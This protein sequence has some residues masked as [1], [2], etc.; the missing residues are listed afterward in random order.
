MLFFMATDAKAAI[1]DLLIT[2]LKATA[3]DAAGATITLERP[4]Q[5]QHGDFSCNVAMQLAKALR[6]K[7]RDIAQ[8]LL[9]NLPASPLVDKAE[10]AGA[11]FINLFLNRGHKQSVVNQILTSGARYGTSAAAERKKIQVEFV[12]ANPTGPLHVG[13][14]RGAAYGACVANVLAAAGHEVS[15]EFYI[16]D[17][18][19]QMDILAVSVWLRYLEARGVAVAFPADGYRGDYVRD[20]ARALDTQH[21]A[22]LQRDF[23]TTAPVEGEDADAAL[24]ALIE[25]AKT[26]LGDGWRALHRFALDAMLADQRDD[27]GGF[28]VQYDRWFSEQSLHDGG[29]VARA[30]DKLQS[31]G[32][33]YDKENDGALWFR[34]TAFGD[35]KDRVVRR[36]NG[37]FTYF[38]SDIAYHLNKIE[39]GYD[40]LIDV[41]GADH[42]G[43]IARVKGAMQALGA[44]PDKLTVTL[45][46][47]AVL[48]R[49]KEKVAMGKRSGDFVTLRELREEVGNDATRFFYV[50]RKSDQHLDFDLELAKSRTNE[51][52]VYYIQYA[53]ARVCSVYAQFA[54][55]GGDTAALV[56]ADPS[57]LTAEAELEL[58]QKLTE[59]PEIVANA[60]RELSPHLIAFYLKDVAGLFHSYYNSTR[61]LSDNTAERDARLALA[62]AVRQVL[63]NGLALLGV[64]APEKM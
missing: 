36:S 28:G 53:H 52:P 5:A 25:R 12:S 24:D 3:P 37:Q 54:Q 6:A 46:Q 44:N 1:T 42:H 49:G 62:G 9:A 32:H 39:R 63:A 61:F 45:V 40:Q 18:G 59:Y 22:Q 17:A 34:S 64:A 48:Y 50:L 19:R 14:G 41:W 33:L 51:N 23:A 4:K 26:K 10:I 11:G 27:L 47:F 30:M 21:G 16:N 58:L 8:Q 60:A 31:N 35:E 57:P 20:I 56:N 15:R 13:H 2:A 43:Y 55:A 38:A 7:P 29:E